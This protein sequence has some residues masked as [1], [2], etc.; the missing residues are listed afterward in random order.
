MRSVIAFVEGIVGQIVTAF[1]T[2][3][4]QVRLACAGLMVATTTGLR[5]ESTESGGTRP[6]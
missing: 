2:L 3:F 4:E 5:G 1:K 6:K